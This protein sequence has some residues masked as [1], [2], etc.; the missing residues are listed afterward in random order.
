[1]P[2]PAGAGSS[3][4]RTGAP[5]CNPTPSKSKGAMIVCSRCAG[6]KFA[7]LVKIPS[8]TAKKTVRKG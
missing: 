1:M 5:E 4:M 2:E 6:L 3:R 8:S 7:G